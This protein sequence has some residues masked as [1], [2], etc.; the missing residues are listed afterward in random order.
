[1]LKA[2]TSSKHKKLAAKRSIIKTFNVLIIMINKSA[3]IKGYN[4][5]SLIKNFF[6]L[7]FIVVEAAFLYSSCVCC[8]SIKKAK[9][10]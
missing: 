7:F 2:L 6:I 5:D 9:S 10:D 3:T 4:K 8:F 1:M